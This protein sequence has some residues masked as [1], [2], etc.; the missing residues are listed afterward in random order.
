[1]DIHGRNAGI[2]GVAL[3]IVLAAASTDAQSRPAPVIAVP[4][5]V[6]L[7]PGSDYRS[8]QSL[9]EL[10]DTLLAAARSAPSGAVAVTLDKYATHFTMLSTRLQ[11]GGAELHKSYSDIFVVLDGEATEVVGG[12]I[13]DSKDSGDE[14]R[15]SRVDGGARQMLRKGDVI[16][17]APNTPHQ[18]L[19]DAGKSITYYVVKIASIKHLTD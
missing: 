17:I 12:T 2:K 15:G 14:V 18:M 8:A 6:Q 5:P 16:T 13:I 11:S 4:P 9:K 7:A 10:E 1:M 3:L 19:V